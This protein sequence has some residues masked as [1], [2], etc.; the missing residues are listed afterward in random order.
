MNATLER[1]LR[2]MRSRVLVRSWDYR[3]RNHA[4]GVWF[5]LRR[6]LA[7]ARAVYSISADEAGQ[8]AAEG[9]RVDLVGEHLAPTKTI[10]V[11]PA[12]RVSRLVSARPLKVSLNA[13]LLAADCLV[14][15]PF[16]A[17]TESEGPPAK[18]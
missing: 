7:G 9:C 6:A 12:E 15:V 17:A 16:Q 11:V 2:Q 13:E 8:L 3:Q 1:R 14:L 5:R 4:R 18:S 10:L